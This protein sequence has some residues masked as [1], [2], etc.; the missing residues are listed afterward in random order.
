MYVYL[1]THTHR[2]SRAKKGEPCSLAQ[3][4]WRLML[5]HAWFRAQGESHPWFKRAHELFCPVWQMLGLFK[6][7]AVQMH[8]SHY[9]AVAEECWWLVADCVLTAS[10]LF[11]PHTLHATLMLAQC[12]Q[13]KAYAYLEQRFKYLTLPGEILL[14]GNPF[15]CLPGSLSKPLQPIL[16]SW[17]PFLHWSLG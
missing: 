9:D 11:I 17:H 16:L 1:Y 7:D 3:W 5:L 6:N 2:V 15:F 4:N 10:F 12:R 13:A 8:C 14:Y